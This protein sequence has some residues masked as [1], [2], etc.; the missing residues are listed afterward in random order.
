MKL[1]QG[2]TKYIIVE[3]FE[4]DEY[5]S[6]ASDKTNAKNVTRKINFLFLL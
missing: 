4:I 3:I 1:I 2:I 6:E 5:L